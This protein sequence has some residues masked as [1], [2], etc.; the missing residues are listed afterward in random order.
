MSEIYVQDKEGEPRRL[1]TS[2]ELQA[3]GCDAATIQIV[4]AKEDADAAQASAETSVE[5]AADA[6]QTEESA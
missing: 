1:A 3:M 2:V 4:K 5:A 6:A